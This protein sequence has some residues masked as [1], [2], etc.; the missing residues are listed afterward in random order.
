MPGGIPLYSSQETAAYTSVVQSLLDCTTNHDLKAA[1]NQE[2]RV[3]ERP[4]VMVRN[5]E[6]VHVR[7]QDSIEIARRRR[8]P[9]EQTN[10]VFV[11]HL[12]TICLSFFACVSAQTF[13]PTSGKQLGLY[14]YQ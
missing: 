11:D 8:M 13:R 14:K 3:S 12:K 7:P 6:R 4:W 10:D 9:K 1:L 2:R 5:Q